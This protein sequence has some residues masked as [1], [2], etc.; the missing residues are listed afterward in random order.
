MFYSLCFLQNKKQKTPQKTISALLAWKDQKLSFK[1]HCIPLMTPSLDKNNVVQGT[2]W[3]LSG[4]RSIPSVNSIFTILSVPLN[5]QIPLLLLIFIP[6]TLNRPPAR[7][8]QGKSL[9]CQLCG[10]GFQ[11]LWSLM[12]KDQGRSMNSV[13]QKL[14][15]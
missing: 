11:D 3:G 8:C 13:I 10:V 1:L 5:L 12:K 9:T 6:T 15:K 4:K 14:I 7:S 2:A